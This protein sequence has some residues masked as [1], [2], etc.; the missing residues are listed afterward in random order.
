MF[1][2]SSAVQIVVSPPDKLMFSWHL[3]ADFPNWAS[4]VR[5][6]QQI[7]ECS[8]QTR[9]I[10][11]GFIRLIKP[12]PKIL[13]SWMLPSC[14]GHINLEPHSQK[15]SQILFSSSTSTCRHN[16]RQ[17]PTAKTLYTVFS[18]L[19]EQ[20]LWSIALKKDTHTRIYPS[21]RVSV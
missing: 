15:Q 13:H 16:L 17:L 1:T 12:L 21:L 2:V 19:R 8:D 6:I 5:E 3:G 4:G 10:Y 14:L 20:N 11:R 9:R 7:A 18:A